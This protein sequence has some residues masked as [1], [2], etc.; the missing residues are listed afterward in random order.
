MSQQRFDY[1]DE[2]LSSCAQSR[3]SAM[4]AKEMLKHEIEDVEFRTFL[5]ETATANKTSNNNNNGD[6]DDACFLLHQQHAKHYHRLLPDETNKI[7]SK[8]EEILGHE[9][10]S[11]SD[12][13]AAYYHY[14]YELKMN[15]RVT[16]F[17]Q[18]VL[19]VHY[20]NSQAQHHRH[21]LHR[22]TLNQFADQDATPLFVSLLQQQQQ[23][24]SSAINSLPGEDLVVDMKKDVWN[25]M[26]DYHALDDEWILDTDLFEI[27]PTTILLDASAN[28]TIGH[29]GTHYLNHKHWKV[30]NK[31]VQ[32]AT[33]DNVRISRQQ[34]DSYFAV[35]IVDDPK[36]DGAL[37]KVK[38]RRKVDQDLEDP[39]I[40]GKDKFGKYLNWATKKNPD[41]VAIVKDAFDQ[42]R[43]CRCWGS[44]ERYGESGGLLARYS[45]AYTDTT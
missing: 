6:D 28:L 20:H 18:S 41:G 5:A 24:S 23:H 33:S 27:S 32:D 9:D 3:L 30:K 14:D 15:D 21:V 40:R 36:F 29:G 10:K 2:I 39:Q 16:R 26:F 44:F 22:V 45:D 31:R 11:G 4:V 35:P 38:P 8:E 42:V 17:L 43:F 12:N 25:T 19:H 1:D 13:D 34:K 7:Q 37:L